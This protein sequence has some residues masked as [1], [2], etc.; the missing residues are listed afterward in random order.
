MLAYIPALTAAPGRMPTDTKLYLYLN[1]GRLIGD[2]AST[3]DN[4]Q[5]LGW[6]P[7]QMIAYLWP[8]GPWYW[9]FDKIGVPDWVAQRLWIATLLF[10]GGMGVRWAARHLGLNV[11]GAITAAV[12][13]QLSPYVLPYISRTSVMLLPWAAV[14]WITGLTVRAA[15]RSKW[16]DP[17]LIALVVLTV[18]AVNATALA[19]IVPAPLLWL[20]HA[21]WQR[22]VTWRRAVLTAL[23]VGVLSVAVSLWWIMMLLI[24][25]KYGA[26]VLA[27]SETLDAVSFTS[28]STET[29]RGLGYW[30]MYVRD[31]FAFT[32]TSAVDYMASGRVIF[33]GFAL[34]V[35]CITGLAVTR[36]VN[37]RYA[38]LLVFC[39]I[40][41]AVGVHPINDP[42]PLVKPLSSAGLAL[43]LRSSTRAIPLSM[44][45]LA[46]GAG[47]LVTAVASIR[48]S[49]GSL[50]VR[51]QMLAPLLIVGLAMLNLPALWNHGFIDPALERDEN[52]PAAWSQ[53]AAALDAS[54]LEARVL[55]LP[56]QEFGAFR[57]GYTVDPPLPGMTA[58]PLAT[59]DLLPLGSP[60]AMDLLYAFDDRIQTSTVE[61]ASIAPVAR[62]LGA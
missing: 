46:L 2:A 33:A 35:V 5:F 49:R 1:P 22:T 21:A 4:R 61:P 8:S 26:D 30:L 20:V 43:A 28:L 14:G 54:S 17:A 53:A 36:W 55:Q 37:R 15:T 16:R 11:T 27:Y 50:R 62:L 18:G 24:Q 6:V 40:V 44:F 23:R 57:W 34:L 58:K 59:R 7:H 48:L 47:A 29:L 60:G 12:V 3:W 45:G 31:P 13:Y 10:L 51:W 19:M 32:T 38:L 9:F 42:A 41:L 56:G 39:G 25:G 52:P